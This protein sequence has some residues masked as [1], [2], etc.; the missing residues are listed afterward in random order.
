M[1]WRT[2]SSSSTL[3]VF[4]SLATFR[5]L[6]LRIC[7][8]RPEKPHIGNWAVPFMNS[9]TGLDLTRVSMRSWVEDM[10]MNRAVEA[11]APRKPALYGIEGR[12]S[13]RQGLWATTAGA[14][15]VAG[16]IEAVLHL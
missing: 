8:A 13:A 5:P 10:A 7:T 15:V 4:R 9:T 12:S 11:A 6:A 1:P 16:Q 3:K 2:A 14:A